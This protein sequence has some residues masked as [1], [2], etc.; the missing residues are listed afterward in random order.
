K[1]PRH[2]IFQHLAAWAQQRSIRIKF[3]SKRNEIT[4]VSTRAVQKQECAWRAS[5]DEVMNEVGPKF[6]PFKALIA[7]AGRA[8]EL[9]V[10]DR[11]DG[12]QGRG[13]SRYLTHFS[14]HANRRQNLFYL[15]ACRFHPR[16]KT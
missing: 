8:W 4:F 15:R 11:E 6:H 7:M 13:Y 2:S 5:R 3:A 9:V 12:P 16:R 10:I 1:E 14:G